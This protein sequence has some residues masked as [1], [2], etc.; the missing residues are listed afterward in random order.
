MNHH[1]SRHTITAGDHLYTLGYDPLMATYY[2]HRQPAYWPP[3][4][5]VPTPTPGTTPAQNDTTL[6]RQLREHGL[7]HERGMR[8]AYGTDWRTRARRNP[9]LQTAHTRHQIILWT[10]ITALT[11]TP[12]P[13]AIT[14]T[15]TAARV[16]QSPT[17]TL[18]GDSYG[19]IRSLEK[20]Q[21]RLRT[22]H[23]LELDTPTWQ[24]LDF[25]RRDHH[26]ET[27]ADT[28]AALEPATNPVPGPAPQPTPPLTGTPPPPQPSRKPDPPRC[29]PAPPGF[30]PGVANPT[31]RPRA[32]L[33]QPRQRRYPPATPTGDDRRGSPPPRAYRAK[34]PSRTTVTRDDQN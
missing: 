24:V 21:H 14:H 25:E 32:S 13:R 7:A 18:F 27:T 9:T 12:A 17:R 1:T 23:H 34:K 3:P 2:A 19:E 28:D 10:A 5:P 22:E 8:A 11:N 6:G 26:I 15:D 30:P 29:S 16:T 33:Q 20:H 31:R 4:L